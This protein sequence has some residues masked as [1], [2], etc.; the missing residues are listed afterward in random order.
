M[1]NVKAHDMAS[2]RETIAYWRSEKS[3]GEEYYGKVN[4]LLNAAEDRS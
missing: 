1:N 4:E 3:A 2:I